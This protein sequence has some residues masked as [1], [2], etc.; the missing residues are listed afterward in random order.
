MVYEGVELFEIQVIYICFMV[1]CDVG[2]LWQISISN[3]IV[4]HLNVISL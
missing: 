2:Y 4:N 3:D 1:Q